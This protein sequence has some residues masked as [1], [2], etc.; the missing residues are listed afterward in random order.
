MMGGSV[1]D[2][3]IDTEHTLIFIEVKFTSSNLKW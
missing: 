3:I 1:P 2:L